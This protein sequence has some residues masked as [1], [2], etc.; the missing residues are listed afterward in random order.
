MRVKK[1]GNSADGRVS[2]SYTILR[3]ANHAFLHP[4]PYVFMFPNTIQGRHA[5][6]FFI[7]IFF[8]IKYCPF[9]TSY[10]LYYINCFN[11]IPPNN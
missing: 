3:Y 4:L 5:F 9:F 1:A 7:S 6:N 10:V 11:K 8:N 2:E